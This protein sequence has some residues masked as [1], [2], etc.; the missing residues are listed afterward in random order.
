MRSASLALVTVIVIG[1][2][3]PALAQTARA[4]GT[5]KDTAGKAMKGATVR[6]MNETAQEIG[7]YDTV[8]GTPSGLDVAG[9]TSSPYDL[10]LIFRALIGLPEAVAAARM[11]SLSAARMAGMARS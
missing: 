9:Q 4:T 6:A 5:V 7:A 11:T 3:V 10:A 2:A 8:A 1:L